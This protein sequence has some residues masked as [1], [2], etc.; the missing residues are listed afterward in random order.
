M[1][2]CSIGPKTA[3]LLPDSAS[4]HRFSLFFDELLPH[5][6]LM[7][8]D[9]SLL[10]CVQ[11]DEKRLRRSSS[12]SSCLFLTPLLPVSPPASEKLSEEPERHWFP[13]DQSPEGHRP[14]G[15]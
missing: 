8:E 4:S 7:I 9:F 14:A 12:S 1:V 13:A 3:L 15:C 10:F 6:K 2:G 5:F 11:M